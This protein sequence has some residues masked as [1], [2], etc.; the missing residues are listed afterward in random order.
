MV[1]SYE[2]MFSLKIFVDRPSEIRVHVNERIKFL[3]LE[4]LAGFPLDFNPLMMNETL[5][6]VHILDF[7]CVHQ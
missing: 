4:L 6:Q 5:K 2:N 1:G 7:T 3:V